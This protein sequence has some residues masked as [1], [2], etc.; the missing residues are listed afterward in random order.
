MPESPN[1]ARN[2]WCAATLFL[3]AAYP[4]VAEVNVAPQALVRYAYDNNIFSVRP[5]DALLSA[6]GDLTRA[7]F[8]QLYDAGVTLNGIWGLQKLRVLVEG[9]DIKYHHYTR[10]NH[11]EYLGDVDF[12]WKLSSLLD[13]ELEFRRDRT[14]APF[15]QRE[16]TVLEVDTNQDATIKVN[17]KL[18]SAFR[19][20]SAAIRHDSFLPLPGFPDAVS[21]ET[22]ERLALRYTGVANLS[23]GLQFSHLAGTFDHGVLPSRYRQNDEAFV[24]T[25]EAGSFSKINGVI[26][27][28]TRTDDTAQ[29]GVSGVTGSFSLLRQVTGKTSIKA[30]IRRAINVYVVGGGQE[31]DTSGSLQADWA[32]TRRISVSARYLHLHS[33]FGTQAAVTSIDAGRSDQYDQINWNVGY[34]AARWFTIRPFARYENRHS[35]RTQF[36]YNGTVVGIDLQG[37]FR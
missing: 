16:S 7:D 21:R 14:M 17:L 26:G 34:E 10:L 32:A 22:T 33:S 3:A 23:Y 35:N 27:Y 1:F 12:N 2:S 8:L 6:Q 36:T 13:G 9:R 5:N 37:Q 11:N 19:L 28:S 4:A 20:E 15:Q 31:L 18:G 29:T 24:F 25:Y 30:E